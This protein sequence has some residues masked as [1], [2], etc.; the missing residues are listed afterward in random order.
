VINA[1]A[2][3]RNIRYSLNPVP[4][5]GQPFILILPSLNNHTNRRS[6]TQDRKTEYKK[7]KGGGH[8][9][10]SDKRKKP[11]VQNRYLHSNRKG[12]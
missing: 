7:W 2:G 10:P 11:T 3:G 6:P 8:M 1:K 4:E 5:K 12:T 9:L